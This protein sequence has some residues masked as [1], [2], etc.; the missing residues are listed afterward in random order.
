MFIKEL[1][2]HKWI[3]KALDSRVLVVA[4]I[5]KIVGDWSAY[6]GATNGISHD[7]E[8][9]RVWESGTKLL[10]EIAK[11]LFPITDKNYRWRD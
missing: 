10:H 7:T 11:I 1:E 4:S 2:N 9:K 3:I 6:V 5:N 8:W